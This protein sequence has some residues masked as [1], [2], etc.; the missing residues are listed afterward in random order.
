MYTTVQVP[1]QTHT[2]NAIFTKLCINLKERGHSGRKG[3]ERREMN[4]KETGKEGE[5]E[6]EGEENRKKER[7]T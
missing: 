4:V 2:S 7:Q 6:G 5:K 1:T 3:R